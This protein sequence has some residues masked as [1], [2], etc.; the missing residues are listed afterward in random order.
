MTNN[1]KEKLH[2]KSKQL[3]NVSIA[4]DE[5]TDITNTGQLAIFVR[6]VFNH[7]YVTEEL[8]DLVPKTDTT[9]DSDIFNCVEKFLNELEVNFNFN[10]FQ[11][12]LKLYDFL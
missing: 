9:T 8:L 3:L 7:L 1:V 10:S 11:L 2:K 6:G 5:S 12:F 4:V